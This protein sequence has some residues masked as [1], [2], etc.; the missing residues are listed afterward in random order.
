MFNYLWQRTNIRKTSELQIDGVMAAAWFFK[1]GIFCAC[2]SCCK[3][4]YV[5]KKMFE[6]LISKMFESWMSYAITCYLFDVDC[7]VLGGIWLANG[8]ESELICDLLKN[9]RIAISDGFETLLKISNFVLLPWE[10][11]RCDVMSRIISP[12][13]VMCGNINDIS[14]KMCVFGVQLSKILNARKLDSSIT[15]IILMLLH[16]ALRI[17]PNLHSTNLK[18]QLR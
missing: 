18:K 16:N 4:W 15:L 11:E 17:V 13:G 6:Q 12:N 3:L 1:G 10:V 5:N 9:N 14:N 2:N 8:F 7:E